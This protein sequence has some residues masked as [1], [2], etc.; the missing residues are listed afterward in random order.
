M[1][2]REEFRQMF[3][4]ELRGMCLAAFA[5]MRRSS[6]I[7]GPSDLMREGRFMSR[8]FSNVRDLIDRMY[9]ALAAAQSD[10]QRQDANRPAPVS[11][12]IP[13]SVG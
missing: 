9:T 4:N 10:P 7:V 8:Q 6:D 1:I 2:T 3:E 12:R 13:K 5:E 11:G